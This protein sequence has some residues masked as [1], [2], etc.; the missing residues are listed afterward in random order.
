M[1]SIKEVATQVLHWLSS[2]IKNGI[3]SLFIWISY[4]FRVQL[5]NTKKGLSEGFDGNKVLQSYVFPKDLLHHCQTN[6]FF[7]GFTNISILPRNVFLKLCWHHCHTNKCLSKSFT[8]FIVIQRNVFLVA[9]LVSLSYIIP[10]NVFLKCLLTSMLQEITVAS[11][12]DQ[13]S[14]GRFCWNHCHV[15]PKALLASLSY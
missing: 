11:L 5:L 13:K 10:G 12:S 6:M 15:F 1:L 8:D 14:L 9:W 2:D 7:K 3:S 4:I